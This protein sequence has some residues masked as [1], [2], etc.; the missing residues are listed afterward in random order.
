MRVIVITKENTDYARSVTMFLNDLS[1]PLNAEIAA[2]NGSV[3][4][5]FKCVGGDA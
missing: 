3:T 4:L 2:R 5:T 1:I